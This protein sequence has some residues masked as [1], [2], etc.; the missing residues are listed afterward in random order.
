[1]AKIRRTGNV[2]VVSLSPTV[3]KLSGF[4]I[5][6]EVVVLANNGVITIKKVEDLV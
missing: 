5:D 3:L 4:D 1:M 2:V 6:D